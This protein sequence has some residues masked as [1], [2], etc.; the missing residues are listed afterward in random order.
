MKDE[1]IG[2]IG[3]S[4]GFVTVCRGAEAY[5]AAQGITGVVLDLAGYGSK[6]VSIFNSVLTLY[7]AYTDITG[8]APISGSY[9][10]FIQVKLNYDVWTKYTY[11]DLGFGDGY[12]LGAV[13]Q[14]VR[15]IDIEILQ[16]YAGCNGGREVGVCNV[17]NKSAVTANFKNPA[18]AAIA[19]TSMPYVEEISAKLYR[20]PIVF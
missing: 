5:G 4:T 13:T 8:T 20:H 14:K 3:L 15:L 17:L 19:N 7:R 6:A 10:D 2:G 11:A 12:R 16:Y 1:L 9:E 18:P